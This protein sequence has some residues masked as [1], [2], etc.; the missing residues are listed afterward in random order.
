MVAVVL[1]W[2][3]SICLDH[4]VVVHQ[5][6]DYKTLFWIF[7]ARSVFC[8]LG[9]LFGFSTDDFDFCCI[10]IEICFLVLINCIMWSK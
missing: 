3:L 10:Y 4:Q 9:Y 8:V 7:L 2:W 5:C 1:F 6:I